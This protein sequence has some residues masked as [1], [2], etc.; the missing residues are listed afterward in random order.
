[1]NRSILVSLGEAQIDARSIC[2]AALLCTAALIGCS[3]APMRTRGARPGSDA[4]P[5]TDDPDAGT[6]DP[7]PRAD[8]GPGSEADGLCNGTDDD[9]DGVVDEGCGCSPGATQACYGGDPALAGRGDCRIGSQECALAG[10]FPAWG[11]CARWTEPRV[12]ICGAG[13]EDCDGFVDEGCDCSVGATERCY[14]SASGAPLGGMPDVGVCRRGART[15]NASPDGRSFMG[16]CE[17]AVGPGTE[18]C[19]TGLDEDCDGRVDEGCE[20]PPGLRE[21]CYETPGG[22][23][24]GGMPGVGR[25]RTGIAL[26][27]ATAT[28]SELGPCEGAIGPAAEECMTGT[29]EDC[30]GLIDEGC[31]PPPADCRIA[32]VLFL[33]DTTG[34]MGGV[35][36]E[37]RRR[38]RDE[39]APALDR[40]VGDLQMAV[41]AYRDF[42]YGSYGSFG[43]LPFELY[44]SSTP[45]LARVQSGIDR[46]S[47]G[48]GADGPE[49]ATEALYQTA[50][51]AGWPGLVPGR[52]CAAGTR[53]MPC[54][55]SSAT[56][57]I[58]LITDAWAHE[59]PSGYGYTG[60]S[61][62]PHRYAETITALRGIGARVVG[63]AVG[64]T[65]LF[66][67]R[68]Y[69][70]DTMAVDAAGTPIVLESSF[71][72][73]GV[74]EAITNAVRGLCGR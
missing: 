30:D 34:S 43:D 46:L 64:P 55:R 28:G 60:I 49:S 67:L 7:G 37:V 52:S 69:A 41:A 27:V 5:G 4:G 44:Q 6:R 63:V 20:C 73:G 35:I 39:I 54:F 10:E 21:S 51:G 29:D 47:A 2:I 18:V 72:S 31:V 68:A 22:M 33:V 32:D 58:I 66:D 65:P 36:S 15:C 25:C 57:I 62:T 26:C 3:E 71:T 17:G 8:G 23:P 13:D 59:G 16:P 24:L 74:A 42:P 53:G 48:G 61:P 38:L 1:M 50:T 9:R 19:A 56:P 11:P 70:R 45:D 14:E 12:E 40:S